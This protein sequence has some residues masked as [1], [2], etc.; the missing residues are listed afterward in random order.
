[1]HRIGRT[2]RAETKGMAVT[3]VNEDDMY[4]FQRIESFIESELE[5]LPPIESLGPGPEWK[6]STGRKKKKPGSGN[7]KHKKKKNFH[8]RNSKNGSSGTQQKS[9]GKSNSNRS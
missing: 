1:M 4:K 5:K 7:F 3:L 9:S 6:E 2:A 8:K